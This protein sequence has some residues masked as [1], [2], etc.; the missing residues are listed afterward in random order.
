[1]GLFSALNALIEAAYDDD[2]SDSPSAK[3]FADH[4]DQSNPASAVRKPR[5]DFIRQFLRIIEREIEG[6]RRVVTASGAVTIDASTD[7]I[8]VVAKTVEA[9]T[10]VNFPSVDDRRTAAAGSVTVKSKM[11][12][13]ALYPLT[14]IPH[15]TD[16]IEGQ[17]TY[18]MDGT[19]QSVRLWP[20]DSVTPRNWE[21]R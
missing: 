4:V 11:S 5:K 16:T 10:D 2:P 13:G 15:G 8:I 1:M 18:T 21:I 3:I 14:L 17:S 12:N 20:D 9:A 19:W 6:S 7:D